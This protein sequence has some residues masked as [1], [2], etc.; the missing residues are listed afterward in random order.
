MRS[1][2]N[3]RDA[4]GGSTEMAAPSLKPSGLRPLLIDTATALVT[5]EEPLQRLPLSRLLQLRARLKLAKLLLAIVLAGD[6]LFG[7]PWEE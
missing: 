6:R 1:T 5:V 3:W 4:G 2:R 7:F